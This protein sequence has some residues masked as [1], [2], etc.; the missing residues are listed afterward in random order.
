MFYVVF[1][2]RLE[3]SARTVHFEVEGNS[4]A[5]TF[6]RHAYHLHVSGVQY[7][8]DFGP[9]AGLDGVFTELLKEG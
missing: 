2:R 1:A 4:F 3:S 8:H 7:L 9:V 5:I 6:N